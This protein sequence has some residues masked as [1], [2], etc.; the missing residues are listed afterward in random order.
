MIVL[1][2]RESVA[3][4][5]LQ[6]RRMVRSVE[7]LMDRSVVGGTVEAIAFTVKPYSLLTRPK[8]G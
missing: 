6:M 1:P 4:E 7:E 2:T 3:V 8:T 5:I